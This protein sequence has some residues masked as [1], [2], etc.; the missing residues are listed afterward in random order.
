MCSSQIPA[1]F[2]QGSF[3]LK[4]DTEHRDMMHEVHAGSKL[5]NSWMCE[6]KRSGRNDRQAWRWFWA[7]WKTRFYHSVKTPRVW[8]LR[9][10]VC[11]RYLHVHIVSAGGEF[12]LQWATPHVF[13]LTQSLSS[14]CAAGMRVRVSEER[15]ARR[16]RGQARARC[17]ILPGFLI[18]KST[19]DWPWRLYSNACQ[20]CA[21]DSHTNSFKCDWRSSCYTS[22]VHALARA[23]MVTW[24]EQAFKTTAGCC[25]YTLS[26]ISFTMVKQSA[27][28][29][30]QQ[31]EKL[32]ECGRKS[33]GH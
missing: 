25:V 10:I 8:G 7:F 3:F 26:C 14:V 24:S 23:H 1:H 16:G 4:K 6:R 22:A 5:C 28:G 17:A 2:W 27:V 11:A 32:V 19:D 21:N 30:L 29:L 33:A 31:E 12:T 9:A 15:A 13:P 20:R 18:R